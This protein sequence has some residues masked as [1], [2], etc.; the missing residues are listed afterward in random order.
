MHAVLIWCAET[1]TTAATATT[2]TRIAAITI[3]QSPSF[4]RQLPTSNH[5][6]RVGDRWS[7]GPAMSCR[8]IALFFL[9]FEIE[10]LTNSFKLGIIGYFD[11]ADDAS[12]DLYTEV[13]A[14]HSLARP[15]ARSPARPFIL[16]R[17]LAPSLH[18]TRSPTH[19]YPPTHWTP[20]RRWPTS[21]GSSSSS[22]SCGTPSSATSTP[23]TQSPRRW[24]RAVTMTSCH[25]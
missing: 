21:S 5:W 17:P 16:P 14:P 2:T 25:I 9:R 18:D 20:S 6:W 22:T 4:K 10:Q 8:R 24:V 3:T 23:G 13:R 7:L 11:P 1:I 12:L 15:L 19:A